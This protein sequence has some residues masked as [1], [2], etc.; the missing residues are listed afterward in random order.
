MACSTMKFKPMRAAPQA[1]FFKALGE[2]KLQQWKLDDSARP[3]WARIVPAIRAEGGLRLEASSLDEGER[4]SG[5]AAGTDRLS[6]ICPGHV[7]CFN[8]LEQLQQADKAAILRSAAALVWADI[9]S[10][11]ALDSPGLLARFVVACHADMKHHKFVLW[12]AFPALVP[13]AHLVQE[14]EPCPASTGLAAA[15]GM[16]PAEALGASSEAV[17]LRLEGSPA[18]L[19]FAF[20]LSRRDGKVGTESLREAADRGRASLRA[21]LAA[22]AV[23]LAV[24]DPSPLP[25]HAGWTVRNAVIAA[26]VGLGLG[27]EVLPVLCLRPSPRGGVVDPSDA[28]AAESAAVPADGAVSA[29]CGSIVVRVRC[30][31]LGSTATEPI[32]P[33]PCAALSSWVGATSPAADPATAG[34][35]PAAAPAE[36]AGPQLPHGLSVAG[37]E[38]QP[39]RS[40]DGSTVM[41]SRPRVVD[42]GRLLDPAKLA[43]SA[44]RL[45]LSLMRWRA[46]PGLDQPLLEGMRCLLL[47]AGTLGCHVARCLIAWGVRSITFVDNGSVA[48]SNPVRQ[49][50][51]EFADVATGTKKSKKALLAAAA[52]RRV[53]PVC[54]PAGVVLTIPMPGHAEVRLPA[55]HPV[56][57]PRLRMA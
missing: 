17:A 54:Q 57:P 23:V 14:G 18:G 9:V 27:G 6:P 33:S 48:H 12:P 41:L 28:A 39:V 42:L 34:A 29:L 26:S 7:L 11:R 56:F 38:R 16:E 45:N 4:D 44:G 19:P 25:R 30:P 13:E 46:L 8:T 5:V 24:V 35:A 40:K 52:L 2:A 31:D 53:S 55:L 32:G 37:W 50:L 22:G 21:D 15:F 49:P 20:V 10:G 1:S 47:G 43:E 51:F 36:V 3:A